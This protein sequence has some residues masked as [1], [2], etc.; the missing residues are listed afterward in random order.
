MEL[1]DTDKIKAQLQSND[2]EEKAKALDMTIAA[3]R[4]FVQIS[5]NELAQPDARIVV[6][7]RLHLWGS[8]AV[9]PL[10]N[11]FKES[12]VD[13]VKTL[14]SLSLLMLNDLTGVPWLITQI[15]QGDGYTCLV[16]NKLLD[17][18]ILGSSD[19]IM[20]RLAN[21]LSGDDLFTEC[22]LDA[23]YKAGIAVPLELEDRTGHSIISSLEKLVLDNPD[24]SAVIQRIA[25]LKQLKR[26]LPKV[27]Y[28]KLAEHDHL[29]RIIEIL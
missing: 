22:L 4:Q 7:E 27:L 20:E 18:K 6:A 13:E 26:K 23:L 25:V 12:D 17:A 16:A 5:V 1:F 15:S 8:L 21:K 10:Q 28:N 24:S 2:L 11:L 9:E 19:A 14:A 29:R 3:V